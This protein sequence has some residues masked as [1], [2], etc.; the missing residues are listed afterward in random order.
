MNLDEEIKHLNN[1]LKKAEDENKKSEL[2]AKIIKNEL[3]QK[4]L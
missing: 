1:E 3:N 2:Q 4:T